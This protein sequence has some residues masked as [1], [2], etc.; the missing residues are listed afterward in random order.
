MMERRL[1]KIVFLFVLICGTQPHLLAQPIQVMGGF[2]KDSIRLGDPI[3]YYLVSRYRSSDNVL[4]PDSTYRFEPFEFQRKKYFPT[5]TRNGESYDSVLYQLLTFDIGEVQYLSLPVFIVHAGDCTRY[6]PPPDSV[7]LISMVQGPV[8]DTVSTQNLPLK[9]NTL[10][11]AVSFLFNYPILLI[12]AGA[13]I[14]TAIIVWL[15]FGKRIKRYFRLKKL[16]KNHSKFIESFTS[17][18]EHLKTQFTVD[19]AETAVSLWKK[20]LEQL[21]QKPYTKLTTRETILQ[22]HDESLGKSL[23][24]LDKAIYGNY[25]AVLNPLEHLQR[26]AH[27]RFTKKMEEMKHG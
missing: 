14:L 8:P 2:M 21:E 7:F 15:M 20:Y 24:L 26:V 4:F 27:D 10:Y 5:Q 3:D 23:H 25:S 22:E 13:L 17:I 11:Q 6:S 19:K 16:Q 9:A 18:M 12:S 1:K